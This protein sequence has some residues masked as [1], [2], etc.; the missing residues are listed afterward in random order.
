LEIFVKAG[1]GADI[2]TSNSPMTLKNFLRDFFDSIEIYWSIGNSISFK[3]I[4]PESNSTN[5]LFKES[6]LEE[7]I[8][9]WRT[10]YPRRII[11]ESKLKPD[12]IPLL[13]LRIFATQC[14]LHTLI[15]LN[16]VF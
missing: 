12:S 11:E 10:L 7:D 1:K 3:P 6:D 2:T 14:L 5:A 9:I 8:R 15:M 13:T 4:V 16:S